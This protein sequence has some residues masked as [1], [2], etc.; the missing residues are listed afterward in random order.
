MTALQL[1]P[2]TIFT[3]FESSTQNALRTVFL[4]SELKGCYFHF[5]RCIWRNVQKL[6]LQTTYSRDRNVYRFG[7]RAVSL[8][9]VPVQ[10]I[11]DVWLSALEDAPLE[12][13]R[14][15][16]FA[17]YVTDYWVEGNQGRH[18]WNHH[19]TVGPR[20]TNHKIAKVFG[21]PHPNI[22]KIVSFFKA[23]QAYV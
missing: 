9:L 8:P 22:F 15:L 5:G 23:E 7:R 10:H 21:A 2:E 4:T 11:E 17:D 18:M 6:G 1:M 16:K 14:V 19:N 20:T 3:D 13:D 12:D